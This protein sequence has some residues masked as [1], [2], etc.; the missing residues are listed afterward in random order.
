[1]L[2]R[3]ELQQR[4]WGTRPRHRDRTVDVCVRKLREKLDRR[5]PTHDYLHTQYGVGYRFGAEPKA[6][7]T[8][9]RPRSAASRR[10]T[11]VGAAERLRRRAAEREVELQRDRPAA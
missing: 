11:G 3:D 6:S 8:R 4:V 2:T 10:T 5:S 7:V 9:L 1:M